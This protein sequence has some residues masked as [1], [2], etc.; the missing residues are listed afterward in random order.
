LARRRWLPPV[1]LVTQETE[2]RRIV[3]QSQPRQIVCKTLSRKILHK[4]RAGGVAQGEGPEFKPQ[5]RQ[6]KK[7]KLI[8]F[9]IVVFG[10]AGI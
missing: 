1:I 10:R 8:Y 6:K 7:E 2:I 4:S 5:Y 9:I 3:V